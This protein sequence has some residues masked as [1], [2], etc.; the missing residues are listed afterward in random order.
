MYTK[1]EFSV[2]FPAIEVLASKQSA[3]VNFDK[4]KDCVQKI[5]TYLDQS[6]NLVY[7]YCE[8]KKIHVQ[9]AYASKNLD[10]GRDYSELLTVKDCAAV[11]SDVYNRFWWSG[12]GIL[13]GIP[14]LDGKTKMSMRDLV[15]ECTQMEPKFFPTLADFNEEFKQIRA[16]FFCLNKLPSDNW[17]ENISKSIINLCKYFKE[18]SPD[19]YSDSCALAVNACGQ[20]ASEMGKSAR[21]AT[22]KET[23]DESASESLNM[24]NLHM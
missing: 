13:H 17:K 2:V 23:P 20:S 6:R 15:H 5:D 3:P 19:F 9:L 14:Y 24:A 8:Q 18:T 10:N 12:S 16:E 21:A 11:V 4:F 1:S 22:E 7:T